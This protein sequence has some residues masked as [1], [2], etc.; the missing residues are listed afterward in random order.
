MDVLT[1]IAE[2][3]KALAWPVAVVVAVFAFRAEVVGLI[4]HLTKLKYSNFEV[5]FAKEVSAVQKRAEAELP[6][7]PAKSSHE[8]VR[9]ELLTLALNSPEAA[10]VEAWRYL[11]GQLFEA[12]NRHN[13]KVA[14]AVRTMPMVV[15]ALLYRSGK[16][17]EAQHT[18]TQRLR[19]LRN[20][21]THTPPGTIDVERAV[22]FVE[23]A[24]RL[25][26]SL[27]TVIPSKAA[28]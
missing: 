28:G 19:A 23:S 11:E 4:P 26:S 25:A 2:L 12:A 1:F 16:I 22:S 18:L 21:A 7:V 15:A 10:I 17:S 3:T 8:A 27:G 9:E 20:E 13:L 6:S 24:L 14:P 5:Q